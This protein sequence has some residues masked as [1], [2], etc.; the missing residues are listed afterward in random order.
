MNNIEQRLSNLSPEK[1]RLFEQLLG[2]QSNKAWSRAPYAAPRNEVERQLADIWS[3]ILGIEA[4]GIHDNYFEL[5]GDSIQCI[6]IM[7]HARRAGIRITT[8][9]L[10]EN[11]TVAQLAAVA[12]VG[13]FTASVAL[14]SS[15]PTAITPVQRWFFDLDAPNVNHWNQAMLLETA[16]GVTAEMVDEALRQVID[17]HEALRL[18]FRKSENGW[19]QEFAPHDDPVALHVTRI[20]EASTQK[21]HELVHEVAEVT[22]RSLD[23]FIGPVIAAAF[24][25]CGPAPGRLLVVCHHLTVDAVSFRIIAEDLET[26][27]RSSNSEAAV[28]LMETT[29]SWR[30]WCH[31]QA[32]HARSKE[33]EPE[34]EYW[35]RH[36]FEPKPLP[37]DFPAGTNLER[38]SQTYSVALSVEETATLFQNTIATLRTDVT[39]ILLTAVVHTLKGW[40][41]DDDLTID[42]EGHG[43]EQ[44]DDMIDLSRTVG[45]FTTIYPVRISGKLDNWRATLRSV[46]ETLITIPRRG[47]GFGLLRYL[48]EDPELIK[49][50]PLVAMNYLGRFDHVLPKDSLLRPTDE[51]YGQL[52]DPEAQRPYVLQV[53]SLVLD[54]RLQ[55]N[56]IYS[57]RLHSRVT[58]ETLANHYLQTLQAMIAA[59]ETSESDTLTPADF[60]DAELSPLELERILKG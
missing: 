33:I 1:R 25:D 34:R 45:W 52:Y 58:I 12:E 6:Q 13:R 17:R 47:Y 54:G 10:F 55:T 29:T 39:G 43:R 31:V 60:P 46:K 22:Q 50:R 48:L 3:N 11:P 20:S 32:E 35:T 51:D 36:I 21:L 19:G 26:I 14:A 7:S 5:G 8:G 27:L 59:A 56:W 57:E 44:F 40:T 30:H 42:L 4:I 37:P 49:K 24:F 16:A 2:E 41:L 18:R 28:S 9:L 53:V 38:D 23:I 15:G